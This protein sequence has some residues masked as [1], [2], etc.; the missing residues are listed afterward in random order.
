MTM[1]R[2]A[3]LAEQ[4]GRPINLALG[5]RSSRVPRHTTKVEELQA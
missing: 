1:A 3:Q 4:R 2:V 5:A